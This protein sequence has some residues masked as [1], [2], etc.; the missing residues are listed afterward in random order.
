MRTRVAALLAVVAVAAASGAC[1]RRHCV[2]E[3][4]ADGHNLIDLSAPPDG[5]APVGAGLTRE[6]EAE[7]RRRAAARAPAGARPY[8]VLAISGGGMYGSFGVGVLGGW[9]ASGTR[10]QFDVVTGISTGGLMATFAF[11]GPEYDA[12]LQENMLGVT[13]GDILRGRSVLHIPFADAAFNSR[14]M[15]RRIREVITPEILAGV[16]QA[17]AAG[18]RLYIGTTNIDTRRLV[19][20]DMGAIA[21]RGTPESLELYRKIVLATSS[22][23]GVFP[24]VRIPVEIDGHWYDELHVDGGVSDEV[25]FRAFMIADLNRAAGIPGGM[26]PPGSGLYVIV[27]GKLYAPAKCVRPRVTNMMSAA[28]RSVVYGKTRDELYRIYLN[29]LETGV[30]FR[31]SALPQAFHLESTGGLSISPADQQRMF[32]EGF[33]IGARAPHGTGW[34]DMPPGTDPAEQALPRTGTRFITPDR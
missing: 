25:I 27:N 23:P 1:S 6:V 8:N 26:A 20:W 15:A 32:G 13:R 22:I 16:A 29:C 19:I 10:P 18:R 31:L 12:V 9:T 14:P 4:M 17:H 11:L 2:P 21:S 5:H 30:E 28:F 33:Q 7:F 3:S 24:P 34:R